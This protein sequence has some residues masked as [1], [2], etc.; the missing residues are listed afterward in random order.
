MFILPDPECGEPLHSTYLCHFV[1]EDG[2][3]EEDSTQWLARMRHFLL[4]IF[5]SP[6]VGDMMFGS[7]ARQA[8]LVKNICVVVCIVNRQKLLPPTRLLHLCFHRR[9]HSSLAHVTAMLA[10]E[11]YT[12][13]DIKWN[14]SLVKGG[15]AQSLLFFAF[16]VFVLYSSSILLFILP[17]FLCYLFV[18]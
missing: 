17:S 8:H 14:S 12:K 9:H 18:L 1:S 11:I 13:V 10:I 5:L 3:V 15:Y 7:H 16:S 2:H 4:A 6:V